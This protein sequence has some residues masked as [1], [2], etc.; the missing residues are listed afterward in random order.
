MADALALE[1]AKK[2]GATAERAR[3]K[4]IFDADAAKGKTMLARHFALTTDMS[5]EAAIAALTIAAPDFRPATAQRAGAPAAT[6]PQGRRVYRNMAD[7]SAAIR[8]GEGNFTLDLT[9]AE[10]TTPNPIPRHPAEAAL[11]VAQIAILGTRSTGAT[12]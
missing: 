1:A 3:I 2:E 10:D 12:V 9:G 8:R 7:A 11:L 6:S 5:V 4:S